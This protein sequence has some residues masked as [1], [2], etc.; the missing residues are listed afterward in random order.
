MTFAELN[1]DQRIQL[2]QRILV[3]RNEAIGE[4]TSY[5]ELADADE[6]VSDEDLEACYDGTEFS[7]DDFGTEVSPAET[8]ELIRT[9]TD[10]GGKMAKEKEPL[11][12]V[13][14]EDADGRMQ[15]NTWPLGRRYDAYSWIDRLL[16]CT[17]GRRFSLLS[18]LNDLQ[19]N[20]DGETVF[21]NKSDIPLRIVNLVLAPYNITVQEE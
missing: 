4:G 1:E 7:P 6:L 14:C 21:A 19:S 3:D 20:D 5:G 18:E 15:L 11:V 12:R 8:G 10:K 17:T 16:G 13:F 2:K 9:T